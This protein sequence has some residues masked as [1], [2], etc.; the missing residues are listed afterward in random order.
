MNRDKTPSR[1]NK[2]SF[3]CALLAVLL[4]HP[5]TPIVRGQTERLEAGRKVERELKGGQS[6]IYEIALAASQFIRVAVEQKSIDIHLSLRAPAGS[7]IEEADGTAAAQGVESI[8]AIAEHSGSYLLEARANGKASGIYSVAIEIRTATARDRHL[9]SADRAIHQ[10]EKLR[11]AKTAEGFRQAASKL[12][13]AVSSL[14]QAD[15][16]ALIPATLRTLGAVYRSA[17]ER[18]KALTA[19]AESLSLFRQSGNDEQ[20]ALLLRDTGEIYRSMQQTERAIELY[21]EALKIHRARGDKSKEA[22][23]LYALGVNYDDIN[24]WG[25]ALNFLIDA[26]ALNRELGDLNGQVFTLSAISFIYMNNGDFDSALY[27]YNEVHEIFVKMGSRHGQAMILG[28]IGAAYLE[29][30]QYEKSLEALNRA[31]DMHKSLS[32]IN[33]EGSTLDGLGKAYALMGDYDRALDYFTQALESFRRRGADY[34]IAT[35]LNAVG[36]TYYLKGEIEKAIEY[37]SQSLRLRLSQGDKNGEATVRLNLAAAERDRGN[38]SAAREHI[39]TAIKIIEDLR[40]KVESEELRASYLARFQRSYEMWIDLI[41]GDGRD[42]AKAAE[43]L[44]ISERARARTLVESLNLS[45]VN[46]RQGVSP[47]LL[48]RERE[49]RN[50]LNA[51]DTQLKRLLSSRHTEEQ[52]AAARKAVEEARTAFQELKA[53]IRE[54]SP[55]YAALTQPAPLALREIQQQVLDRD[56]LLLEYFLGERRSYLWAV[57]STGQ[58]F[59]IIPRRAD[60]ESAAIRFYESLTARNKKVTFETKDERRERIAKADAEQ[61]EAAQ[62]LSRMILAPVADQLKNRRLLIVPDGAL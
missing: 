20:T 51:K 21:T 10:S 13:E 28:Y 32:N 34:P 9:V 45:G 58:T 57:T 41:V 27:Y 53:R 22:D 52:A 61:I 11:Q 47:E 54:A 43:S 56:S 24:E 12:E 33:G 35:A 46:I 36:K 23:L 2:K 62:A 40:V 7:I 1:R 25:K 29:L 18:E 26:L 6:H 48:I 37:L 4:M 55:K 16:T 44:E 17:G 59:H 39:E 8:S 19:Y 31:L 38:T 3:L 15:E 60:I 30:G 14:K 5:F 49:A 50:N 42:S